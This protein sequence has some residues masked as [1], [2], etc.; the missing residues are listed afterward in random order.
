ML[1]RTPAA[2]RGAMSSFRLCRARCRSRW[3]ARVHFDAARRNDCIIAF[4]QK[5]RGA[6]VAAL[7]ALGVDPPEGFGLCSAGHPVQPA[8]AGRAS[9][10]RTDGEGFHRLYKAADSWPWQSTLL[11]CVTY[12]ALPTRA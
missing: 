2:A 5:W 8:A 4:G 10:T 7:K 9:S 12:L 3:R 11:S 1:A 6:A